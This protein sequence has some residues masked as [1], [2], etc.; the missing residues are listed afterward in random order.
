MSIAIVGVG[1]TAY[2]FHDPRSEAEPALDAIRRALAD[3]GLEPHDV[4]GFVSETYSTVRYAPVDEISKR[5]GLRAGAELTWHEV[6]GT[7]TVYTHTVVRRSFLPDQ[8]DVAP[9]TI[10]LVELDGVDGPRLVANLAAGVDPRIGMR[11][12][13]TFPT[14]GSHAHP[15]FVPAD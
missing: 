13:P 12:R 3:A 4:D 9:F 15:V 1:E 14:V 2:S 10:I 7:G 8:R 6:E 11:V 5:L